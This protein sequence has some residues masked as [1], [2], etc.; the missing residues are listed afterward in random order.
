METHR[1]LPCVPDVGSDDA[2]IGH[3]HDSRFFPGCQKT[4]SN[5]SKIQFSFY[6]W[7][8]AGMALVQHRDDTVAVAAISHDGYGKRLALRYDLSCGRDLSIDASQKQLLSIL[9][10]SR[11]LFVE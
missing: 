11:G 4:L 8:P 7:L 2:A 9:P 10:F 6:P 5:P 3:T 1:F